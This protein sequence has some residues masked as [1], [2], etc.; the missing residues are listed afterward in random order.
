MELS[1]IYKK[2]HCSLRAVRFFVISLA[3]LLDSI[4]D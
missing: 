4:G 2:T 1:N 3:K